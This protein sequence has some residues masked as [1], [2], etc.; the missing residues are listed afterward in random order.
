MRIL[1]K[2]KEQFTSK[3][4]VKDQLL[5]LKGGDDKR[6]GP[7]IGSGGIS[8]GTNDAGGS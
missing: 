3:T 4:L 2:L 8:G 6:I 1:K 5:H 7:S